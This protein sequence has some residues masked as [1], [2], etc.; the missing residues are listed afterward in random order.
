VA[1]DLNGP[2]A[3]RLRQ[4]GVGLIRG[5]CPWRDL[6]PSPGRFDWTCSDNLVLGARRIAARSYITVECA[7]DWTHARPACG[8]LPANIDDWYAFVQNYVTRYQGFNTILGIWNEPN[9]M[10]NGS[11]ADYARLFINASSAR[12]AVDSTF[13][14]AGPETSHHA[15]ASGYYAQAMD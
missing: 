13:V 9:L 4:L 11:A 1:F 14:L 3:L 10:L 5:S 7:P 15:L 8:G 6:E 2:A 12:N